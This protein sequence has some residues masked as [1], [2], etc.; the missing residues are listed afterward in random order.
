[1]PG[2]ESIVPIMKPYKLAG[3]ELKQEPTIVE[4]GD[5]RIG[6]NEVV[7]MAGPCAIENEQIYVETAKK[8]KA[9]GAKILRGGASSPVHPLMPSKA[10]KKTD[11]K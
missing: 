1:M 10:W 11:L 9:A 8:V 2:V 4:V 7:V 6:G 5:V 3:K